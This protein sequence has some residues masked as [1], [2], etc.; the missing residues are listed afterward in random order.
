MPNSDQ[1]SPPV[2]SPAVARA[3]HAGYR[4]LALDPPNPSESS[5]VSGIPSGSAVRYFFTGVGSGDIGGQGF[6]AAGFTIVLFSDTSSIIQCPRLVLSIDGTSVI[7]IDGFPAADFLI[8]TR[9]FSNL[10]NVAVG[11]SR[12][13]CSGPDLVDLFDPAFAGYTLDTSLGP[14]FEDFPFAVFQF[15]RVPTSLGVDPPLG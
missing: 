8:G 10:T 15:R 7:D 13:S 3:A 1:L 4:T 9:V 12:A 11:F 2:T 6:V 14:I 5:H